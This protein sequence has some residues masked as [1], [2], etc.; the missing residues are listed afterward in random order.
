MAGS[1]KKYQTDSKTAGRIPI[2]MRVKAWWEGDELSLRAKSKDSADGSG[3]DQPVKVELQALELLQDVW[4]PGAHQPTDPTFTLDFLRPLGLDPTM[5]IV[6]LGAGF[7]LLART[8]AAD[9]GSWVQGLEIDE[10]MVELGAEMS[11]KAG[12]LK[13]AAIMT[14]DPDTHEFRPGY[15]DTVVAREFLY[16]VTKKDLLLEKCHVHLKDFGQL[17]FTDFVLAEGASAT[18]LGKLSELEKDEV[19]YWSGPHYEKALVNLNFDLRINE[20]MTDRFLPMARAAWA[21]FAESNKAQNYGED[22]SSILRQELD[23]WSERLNAFN[24]GAL[25]VRRFHCLKP[26]W[27]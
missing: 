13:K 27:G 1:E 3:K 17:L 5:T 23:L 6:N 26:A 8:M 20:D 21:Q 25:E 4:G 22:T 7:G 12:L 2:S 15:A 19:T 10:D 16:R 24:R 9:F 14:F 11:T 18:D